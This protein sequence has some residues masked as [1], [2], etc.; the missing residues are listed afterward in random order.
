MDGTL[1]IK[2]ERIIEHHRFSFDDPSIL[3]FLARPH[4]TDLAFPPVIG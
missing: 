4:L 3:M 1:A 2:S